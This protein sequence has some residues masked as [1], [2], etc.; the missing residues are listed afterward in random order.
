[1]LKNSLMGAL[2]LPLLFCDPVFAKNY[3]W[4]GKGQLYDKRNQ[5]QVTC[6]LTQEKNVK[7]F[8]GE[9]SVKCFY[10]CTDK[11]EM[12]VNIHSDFACEKQIKVPRG[13]KRDWRGKGNIY[14]P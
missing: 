14:S 4:S 11:E 5:Y 6:R 12:V 13:D 9:D 3:K 2:V 7:P 1:V 10:V 8:F